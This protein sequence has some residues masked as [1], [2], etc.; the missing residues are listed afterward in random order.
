MF[1]AAEAKENCEEAEHTEALNCKAG[2]GT[3]AESDLNGLSDRKALSC[4]VRC[5]NVSVSSALHTENANDRAHQSAHEECDTAG[6][7]NEECEDNGNN[8]HNDGDALVLR[9]KEG[10]RA[11]TDDT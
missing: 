10:L 8:S 3:A 2:N 11:G 4:L 6:L 5:T 9:L 7:L 1:Y